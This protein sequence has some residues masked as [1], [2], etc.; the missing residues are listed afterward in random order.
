MYI[1]RGTYLTDEREDQ[2]SKRNEKASPLPTI[3]EDEKIAHLLRNL[4]SVK[5]D[6]AGDVAPAAEATRVER[7][8]VRRFR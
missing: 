6:R 2:R 3:S 4:A 1:H 8:V 7:A 5:L